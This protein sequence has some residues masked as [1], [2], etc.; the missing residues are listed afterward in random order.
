MKRTNES[1]LVAKRALR[2]AIRKVT[3]APAQFDLS[4]NGD[5]V[6]VRFPRSVDLLEFTPANARDLAAALL[7]LA[8]QAELEG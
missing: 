7:A 1:A 8:S 5:R 3:D 2:D 4:T 6:V